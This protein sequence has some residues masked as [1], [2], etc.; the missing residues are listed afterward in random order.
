MITFGYV[1]R[2]N[3]GILQV[4]ESE[5]GLLIAQLE[6][7]GPAQRAGLRGPKIIIQK[8]GS[9]EYRAIDRAQAD[10]IVAID[11][12]MVKTLDELLEYIESKKPDSTVSLS[13]IRNGARIILPVTLGK[14]QAN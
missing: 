7:G 8:Q 12:K 9:V 5:H 3:I 11:K 6:P 1:V 14:I 10:L 2:P 13:I 4:Y